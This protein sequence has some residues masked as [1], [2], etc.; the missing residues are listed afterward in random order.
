MFVIGSIGLVFYLTPSETFMELKYKK[1][2]EY[3]KAEKN[4]MNNPNNDTLKQFAH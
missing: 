3:V 2:P 1:Y 4:L